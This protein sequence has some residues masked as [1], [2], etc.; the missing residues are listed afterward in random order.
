MNSPSTD[1]AD[2]PR[3]QP[4]QI[5]LRSDELQEVLG[6]PP[7]WVVRSGLWMVAIFV[8]VLLAIAFF[9]QYPDTVPADVRITTTV[10]PTSIE[11]RV[12][13]ELAE[14]RVSDG[15]TVTA[16]QVLAVLQSTTDYAV[17][18]S[19]Q[20]WEQQLST[21]WEDEANALT[22]PDFT[23]NWGDLATPFTEFANALRTYQDLEQ[24]D[25]L[26]HQRE[27]ITQQLSTQQALAQQLT[28]RTALLEA[29]VALAQDLRDRNEA[30]F[31][32]GAL[33]EADYQQ[34]Q[35]DLLRD[36][37]QLARTQEELTQNQLRQQELQRQGQ[38]LAQR[39]IEQEQAVQERLRTAHAYL[40]ATV[41]RWEEQY[42]LRA[43]ISGQ[44]AFYQQRDLRQQINTGE[45][46][47][48]I[49][50]ELDSL[51]AHAQLSARNAG[52]VQAGQTV[53]IELAD[54]PAQDFGYVFGT[55]A[56]KSNIIRDGEYWLQI[57]LPRGLRTEVAGDLPFSFFFMGQAYLFGLFLRLFAV[58]FRVV[59][60]RVG[61][62]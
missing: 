29:D 60:G 1:Q 28:Q 2:S 26:A 15:E 43:P 44:V 56:R 47:F 27:Q 55:V 3:R 39:E 38:L 14:L 59:R 45:E 20:A 40:Q 4:E 18:Q 30:L 19:W 22:L 8:A 16:E 62:W 52:K 37:R 32:S 42:L 57:T 6:Q 41:A 51:V 35:K 31:T 46:V 33:S 49:L 48:V 10:L 53:R 23:G 9:L 58:F 36:Q 17:V 50:P 11:A 34:A 61:G 21:D 54:F 13:A 12:D 7:H 25:F 5:H 24:Q